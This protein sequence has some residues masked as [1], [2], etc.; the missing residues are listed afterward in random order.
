[1]VDTNRLKARL[2]LAGKTQEQLAKE[3]NMSAN[4][5]NCK[6]NGRS[7]F[8]C[9]EVDAICNALQIHEAKEKCDI[10]F[11]KLSR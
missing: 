9:N 1:M 3:V 7:V 2:A 5:L 6:I 11:A 10:F 4:S 8:N